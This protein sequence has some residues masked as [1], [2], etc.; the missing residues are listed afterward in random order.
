MGNVS[1]QGIYSL[2]GIKSD[3][4]ARAGRSRQFDSKWRCR[5]GALLRNINAQI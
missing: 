5:G 1:R 2:R 4:G 3:E